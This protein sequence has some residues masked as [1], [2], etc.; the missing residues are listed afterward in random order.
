MDGLVRPI[1]TIEAS[2][3][4]QT[5]LVSWSQ[6]GNNIPG[7][8]RN[9]SAKARCIRMQDDEPVHKSQIKAKQENTPDRTVLRT[10]SLA[11]DLGPAVSRR[12]AVA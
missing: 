11:V 1:A 6:V 4:E 12:R 3:C 7:K 5:I 10:F 2:K 9:R 8:A